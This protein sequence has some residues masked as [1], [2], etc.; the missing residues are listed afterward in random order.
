MARSS[1]AAIRVTPFVHAADTQCHRE[2]YMARVTTCSTL[3]YA[4]YDL[5][6]ALQ[7]ISK[8]GFTQV[9]LAHL[10]SYC[11]HCDPW[12]A[13]PA[14]ILALLDYYGLKA[15]STNQSISKPNCSTRAEW[16]YYVAQPADA[17]AYEAHVH[18]VVDCASELGLKVAMAS[19]TSRT[20]SQDMAAD[21]RTLAG[22]LSRQADYAAARGVKLSTELPHLY[23]ICYDIDTTAEFFSYVTSEHLI[24]TVETAH[25]GVG[26]YDMRYLFRR[27]GVRV[28]HVHLR[29]SAGPDTGD[30]AQALELTPGKGVI[31]FELFGQILD[32]ND[33]Q[34]EVT[35]EFEYRGG[36]TVEQIAAE[37]DFGIAHLKACGWEFPAGV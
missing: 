6:T 18:Q 13:R 12:R 4:D 36:M 17:A 31:D 29:D 20:F 37:Y 30:Y 5:E 22:I 7:N 34:G 15:V 3:G 14:E 28:G 23:T 26:Q 35:L 10:V 33:Y 24:D 25:W 8:R 9:E 1:T 11:R 27:L 21:R 32:E 2:T 19:L 16:T